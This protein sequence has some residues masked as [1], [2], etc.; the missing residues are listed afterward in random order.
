MRPQGRPTDTR[1]AAGLPG[2]AALPCYR[3]AG[4]DTGAPFVIAYKVPAGMLIEVALPSSRG[5]GH[6]PFKA[7]TR[8]R[9]P[10]GAPF[11][12]YAYRAKTPLAF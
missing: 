4:L 2:A 10:L 12:L 5:L 9:I 11:V 3:A 7:A 6:R 8:I 1:A